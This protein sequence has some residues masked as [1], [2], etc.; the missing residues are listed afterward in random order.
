QPLQYNVRW[1]RKRRHPHLL[2]LRSSRVV[3]TCC[4]SPADLFNGP[5]QRSAFDRSSKEGGC[6][7][8]S[9]GAVNS[10]RGRSRSSG[11]QDLP[12][13]RRFMNAAYNCGY[14]IRT[15]LFSEMENPNAVKRP[16]GDQPCGRI[17]LEI[18]VEQWRKGSSASID[19]FQQTSVFD[20]GD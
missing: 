16:A 18:S 3:P 7:P 19:V 1:F 4:F 6:S 14:S 17:Q 9:E 11:C 20:W 2:Q 10:T 8:R 15:G 5:R 13:S 12:I